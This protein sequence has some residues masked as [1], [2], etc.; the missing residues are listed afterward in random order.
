M[1]LTTDFL[2]KNKARFRSADGLPGDFDREILFSHVKPG[3]TVGIIDS[4]GAISQGRATI[5]SQNHAVLNTGG[6]HGT[7]KIADASNTIYVSGA[8]RILNSKAKKKRTRI[9]DSSGK[10][11]DLPR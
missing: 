5:R 8:E 2:A 4:R 10:F 9:A 6:A 11:A 7:P 1:S 3:D